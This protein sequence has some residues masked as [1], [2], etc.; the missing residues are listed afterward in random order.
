MRHAFTKT[1]R[2]TQQV[3]AQRNA[4]NTHIANAMLGQRVSLKVGARS[5]AHG[6]VAGVLLENGMPRIVVNGSCYDLNQVLTVTPASF[7]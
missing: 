1:T 7:N 6:I 4:I 2:R 3:H 5:S